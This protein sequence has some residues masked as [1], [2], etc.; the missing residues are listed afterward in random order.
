MIKNLVRD[1]LFEFSRKY[2]EGRQDFLDLY[3]LLDEQGPGEIY[4]SLLFG[5]QFIEESARS[6]NDVAKLVVEQGG[7]ADFGDNE[8]RII[9]NRSRKAG[10]LIRTKKIYVGNRD[11]DLLYFFLRHVYPVRDLL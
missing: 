2:I 9:F 3:F 4:H 5:T 7:E 10:G 6:R 11:L 1:R 8:E